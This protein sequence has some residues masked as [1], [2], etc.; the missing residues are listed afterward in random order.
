MRV[1]VHRLS[2]VCG[3]TSDNIKEFCEGGNPMKV[4]GVEPK[5][6]SYI[7]SRHGTSISEIFND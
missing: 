4:L 7:S 6:E 3:C 1:S 5:T 2:H